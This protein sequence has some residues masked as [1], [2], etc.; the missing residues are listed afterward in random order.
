MIVLLL[1]FVLLE[2]ELAVSAMLRSKVGRSTERE[3]LVRSQRRGVEAGLSSGKGISLIPKLDRE[4]LQLMKDDRP[5]VTQRNRYLHP[6]L[7][8]P[9]LI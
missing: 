5:C 4:L 3:S 6:V 7:S 8:F 1:A 9:L 2:G